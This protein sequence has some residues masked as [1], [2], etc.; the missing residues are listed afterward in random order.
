M[1][2]HQQVINI[3]KQTMNRLIMLANIE[4]NNS[5]YGN[6]D[7]EKKFSEQRYLTYLNAVKILQEE[8]CIYEPN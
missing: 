5:V 6:T 7:I 3:I 2:V 8:L 1:Q 4:K